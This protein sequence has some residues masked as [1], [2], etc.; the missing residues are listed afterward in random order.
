MDYLGPEFLRVKSTIEQN[1]L[2]AL[3]LAHAH[4]PTCSFSGDVMERHGGALVVHDLMETSVSGVYAAGDCC[5]YN[6]HSSSSSFCTDSKNDSH[7]AIAGNHWFQM[8]LWTQ[9]RS[10]GTYAAQCMCN[11]ND[12]LGGDMFFEIFA[13]VT[14]F[15][16][17][18]VHY[19]AYLTLPY[20]AALCNIDGSNALTRAYTH[21]GVVTSPWQLYPTTLLTMLSV[22]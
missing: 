10:M 6:T 14:R 18:K 5:Y 9:A 15:F 3:A 13:H 7:D 17:H 19:G 21:A 8:R 2:A 1:A 22:P 11:K 12:A 20:L 4:A 16:G